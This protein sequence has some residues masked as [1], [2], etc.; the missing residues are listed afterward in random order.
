MRKLLLSVF[1][2]IIVASTSTAYAQ[3][4]KIATLSPEGSFW[5]NTLKEAGKSIAAKTDNRVQFRFYPGGV[6]GSDS[7]VLKK[8]RIG[9][10]HGAMFSGGA[11]APLA[12]NAQIYTIPL[13]FNTYAEVDYVRKHMDAKIEKSIN[14]AGFINFGLAEGGFAYVMSKN[15][16]ASVD[17]LKKNKVWTPSEDAAAEAAA[18]TFELSPV[19]LSMGDVLTGLQTDLINTITASPIAA[20]A[21]QWHSQIKYIT[22]LPIAYF[23]VLM[24]VDKKAFNKMSATDQKIVNTEMRAAFVKINNQN[25]ADNDSAFAALKKQGI[26]MVQ[27]NTEQLQEWRNKTQIAGGIFAEKG[28]INTDYQK[29]INELLVEF[30]KNAQS[31]Q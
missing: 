4:L 17:E 16:I 14:D 2:S 21:L 22:D 23:T 15:A 12:P 6:M 25:R 29:R 11:I 20:I 13:L 5:T 24:A 27:P 1:T 9:Q 8:I 26:E 18:E 10:L 19:A 28:K 7:A 31:T 3:T 30:R